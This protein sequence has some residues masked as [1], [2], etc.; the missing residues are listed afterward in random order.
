MTEV[1]LDELNCLLRG[2]V[3]QSRILVVNVCRKKVEGDRMAAMSP[4]P[5]HSC[6]EKQFV[7]A[8]VVVER[9]RDKD[10]VECLVWLDVALFAEVMVWMLRSATV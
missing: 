7:V 5:A 2:F 9:A 8:S 10:V 1:G 4:A 6:L 3:P